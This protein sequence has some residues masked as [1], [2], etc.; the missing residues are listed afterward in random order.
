MVHLSFVAL[1]VSLSGFLNALTGFGFI[2][3]AA[4]FLVQLLPPRQAA[5][6]ALLL[7][8]VVAAIV[9]FRER[10]SID[11]GVTLR[12][13]AA[14]LFGIPV[15][16]TMLLALSAGAL[17]ILVG[18]IVVAVTLFLVRGFCLPPRTASPLSLVSGFLSGVL[19]GIC[20]MSGAIAAVF[21]MGQRWQPFRIRPTIAAFNTIVSSITLAWLLFSGIIGWRECAFALALLPV[22]LIGLTASG[23]LH[24][25][26]GVG[27]FRPLTFLL[28]LLAG[29]LAI[30]AGV[31]E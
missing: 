29:L 16:T 30:L 15:G 23:L 4:P 11:R 6:V 10:G 24:D 28:V 31:R 1:V 5:S 22:A 20:G 7:G 17:K 8:A 27:L 3:L 18:S 21:F 25:R 14:A 12:M 13:S 9:A 19:S 2:I 26:V